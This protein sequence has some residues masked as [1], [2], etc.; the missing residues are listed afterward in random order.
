LKDRQGAY[1][2]SKTIDYCLERDEE[3]VEDAAAL[4]GSVR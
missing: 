1:S 2:N 4:F 3:M